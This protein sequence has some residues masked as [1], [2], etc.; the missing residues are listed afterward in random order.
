MEGQVCGSTHGFL[1][2]L[3]GGAL[4]SHSRPPPG[5]TCQAETRP[6]RTTRTDPRWRT[7]P[8][9]CRVVIALNL[10]TETFDN[11]QSTT[12]PGGFTERFK[13]KFDL[14]Q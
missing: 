11:Y 4:A 8:I 10:K 3:C 9:V 5:R 7:T 2:R 14:Y 13:I 12:L 1:R 6:A